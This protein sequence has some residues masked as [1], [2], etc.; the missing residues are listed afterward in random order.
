ME[1]IIPVQ[2]VSVITNKEGFV[3]TQAEMSEQ[4][5]GIGIITAKHNNFET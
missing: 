2:P 1:I 3:I 5:Q 4:G